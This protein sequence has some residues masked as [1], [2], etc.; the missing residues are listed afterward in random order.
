[1]SIHEIK[2]SIYIIKDLF[3]PETGKC[4]EIVTFIKEN[5]T[6][7]QYIEVSPVKKK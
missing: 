6:L 2:D 4:D 1:M 7:Q 3:L 5:K